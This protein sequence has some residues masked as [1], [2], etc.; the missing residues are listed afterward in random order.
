MILEMDGVYFKI[1]KLDINI[2]EI[3]WMIENMD[4]VDSSHWLLFI[5]V[6]FNKTKKKDLV[7]L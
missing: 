1:K 2:L 6:N 5:K 4:M 7:F 3:G